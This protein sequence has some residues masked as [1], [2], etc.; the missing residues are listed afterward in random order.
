VRAALRPAALNEPLSDVLAWTEQ[1]AYFNGIDGA[2]APHLRRGGVSEMLD[3]LATSL[4]EDA[5]ARPPQ[6]SH[7]TDGMSQRSTLCGP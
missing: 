6:N 2:D 4:G 7:E 1:G 5:T 3:G